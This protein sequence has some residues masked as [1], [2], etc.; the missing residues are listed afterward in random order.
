[1]AFKMSFSWDVRVLCVLELV[2][3]V[4]DNAIQTHTSFASFQDTGTSCI[5]HGAKEGLGRMQRIRTFRDYDEWILD[6]FLV[7]RKSIIQ[8]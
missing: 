1:M 4:E 8:T 5:A 3:T 2:E 7:R 6:R